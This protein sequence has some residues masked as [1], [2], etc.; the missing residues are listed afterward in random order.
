MGGSGLLCRPNHRRSHPVPRD[1][2]ISAGI[3]V[4][5]SNNG[6]HFTSEPFGE[7][8]RSIGRRHILVTPNHPAGLGS[9]G[10][11][12]RTVKAAL[13]AAD[14]NGEDIGKVAEGLPSAVP[15]HAACDDGSQSV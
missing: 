15:E 14:M 12:N 9:V 10:R 7:Y 4:L 5:V 6:M 1:N 11:A 8:L 13:Q 2:R 3:P